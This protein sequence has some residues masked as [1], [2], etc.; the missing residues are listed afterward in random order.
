MQVAAKY[1]NKIKEG[2]C[3]F[4]DVYAFFN[5]FLCVMNNVGTGL[6]SNLLL[7]FP[8]MIKFRDIPMIMLTDSSEKTS[9]PKLLRDEADCQ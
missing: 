9:I 7:D 5:T 6:L 1:V 2:R 3:S 8:R 4:V